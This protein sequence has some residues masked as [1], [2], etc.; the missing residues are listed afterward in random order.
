MCCVKATFASC[1]VEVSY[2]R[3]VKGSCH[4]HRARTYLCMYVNLQLAA[5]MFLMWFSGS[6]LMFTKH[7]NRRTL[8]VHV[9]VCRFLCISTIFT[10]FNF[11]LHFSVWY[12]N[13][14]VGVKKLENLKIKLRSNVRVWSCRLLSLTVFVSDVR[15]GPE[16]VT[17]P[18]FLV[19]R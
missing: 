7:L 11:F 8:C 12:K 16:T 10:S 2:G 18:A 9:W 3:N 14:M 15:V 6:G 13:W 5:K 17:D 19:T 1:N 4:I